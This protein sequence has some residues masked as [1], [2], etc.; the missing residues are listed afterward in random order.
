MTKHSL[1]LVGL[2]AA[3]G[4]SQTI[5]R[6]V[7]VQA[8]SSHRKDTPVCA[9]IDLP[10]SMS[11]ATGTASYNGTPTPAQVVRDGDEPARVMWV[12][13]DLPAGKE[14]TYTLKLGSAV[15]PGTPSFRWKDSS[16]GAVTSMDLFY[17]DRPVMRY[18]HTPFDKTNIELT[19]KPFHH[20]FSPDGSTRL[21]QGVVGKKQRKYPHHRGIY[22]GYNKCTLADG[23]TYDVWHA[24]KGEH[25]IHKAVLQEITGPVAGGHVVKIHW[26]DR[27]GKA[28]IEEQRTLMAIRQSD[29]HI[30]VHFASTLMPTRGPV[31]LNG[32][33]QHAG[34]QWRS[35]EEVAFH[36][37]TT[38][39]LRPAT[40]AQLPE[41]K[42]INTDEHKDLPWNAIKIFVGGKPFTVAYLTDPNNPDGARFSER[43]YGRFGEFIPWELSKD[44]PLHLE[45]RWWISDTHDITREQIQ[46]TYEDLA[47]PPQVSVH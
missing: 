47:S 23:Q 13:D 10:K 14:R 37:K 8:G 43:L 1:L 5:E 6:T 39:Y 46:S 18:M 26:C 25:Q 45:Y 40:W 30:L 38:R 3:T 35:A 11:G 29:G 20:V 44:K 7:T 9:K 33:R 4:C 24:H 34:A 22:F 2:I 41:D 21:T 12:I 17:G 27:Q 16:K 32:D 31:S 15:S 28:F 19:K 36:E 42:Q